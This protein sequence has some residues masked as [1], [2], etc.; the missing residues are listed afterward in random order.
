[1]LDILIRNGELPPSAAHDPV[2]PTTPR[3]P[4]PMPPPLP[5][6][7]LTKQQQPPQLSHPAVSATEI[8]FPYIDINELGLN[9]DLESLGEAMEL[10]VYENHTTAQ[11]TAVTPSP[12]SIVS[13]DGRNDEVTAMES[14]EGGEGGGERRNRA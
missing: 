10:G 4:P 1:M 8:K 14:E 3:D 6:H 12:S 5:S 9:L 2:T 7:L 13:V 11:H